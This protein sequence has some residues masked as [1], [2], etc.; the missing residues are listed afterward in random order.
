MTRSGAALHEAGNDLDQAVALGVAMNSVT[1]NAES[2]GQTLKTVSMYLR[3]AK[4]DLTAMGESTDGCAN[5][6]SELRSELKKLTGVDIMADA[7]GTQFKSTYDIL[8]EIS[9]VWGKLTDVDRANVTELLGGKRNAV[10]LG[11]ELH[12]ILHLAADR[13]GHRILQAA[14]HL[15]KSALIN[16]GH[17]G[18]TQLQKKSLILGFHGF[19]RIQCE[20]VLHGLGLSANMVAAFAHVIDHHSIGADQTI[21]QRLDGHSS[22]TD[23]GIG[24]HHASLHDIA[25]ADLHLQTMVDNLEV[26]AVFR[27]LTGHHLVLVISCKQRQHRRGDLHVVDAAVAVYEVKKSISI[28]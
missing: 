6:V 19:V 4:T 16:G 20:A 8:M 23:L 1:Q 5:S 18:V 21:N 12:H 10:S 22:K 25:L 2:T 3:A 14:N 11:G 28:G 15:C 9:K 17:C 24:D 13:H 26:Q 27:D 7:A